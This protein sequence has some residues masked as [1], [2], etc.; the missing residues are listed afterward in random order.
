M[1][2]LAHGGC[3][4]SDEDVPPRTKGDPVVGVCA[5]KKQEDP[6][7][8]Y[9]VYGNTKLRIAKHRIDKDM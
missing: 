3:R 6:G 1:L 5:K 4:R 9:L 7:L 8:A 2:R